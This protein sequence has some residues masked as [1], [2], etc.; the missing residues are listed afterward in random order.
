MARDFF[1]A[2]TSFVVRATALSFFLLI[3]GADT[4]RN[5]LAQA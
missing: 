5:E 3:T 2:V 4:D 1:G